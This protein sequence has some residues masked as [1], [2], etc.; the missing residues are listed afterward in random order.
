MRNLITSKKWDFHWPVMEVLIAGKSSIDL[1]HLHVNDFAEATEFIR[2]YGYEP[3]QPDDA[4][5]MQATMIEAIHFIVKFLIP[6]E[7]KTK[8]QIPAEIH[9]CEDV[10]K[11][12][13]FASDRDPQ[14]LSR[15]LWAC[16]I[17]RVMH[18]IAHLEGVLML[19][20]HEIA[21][22]QIYSRFSRHIHHLEDG[23]VLLGEGDNLIELERVEWKKE[24]SRESM[25]LKLLH[26]PA[27]VAETIYDPIGVRVITKKLSDVM[28]VVKFLRQLYM[29]SFPNCNPTRARNT[30]LD[31][32][33]FRDNLDSIDE[34]LAAGELS[35]EDVDEML[36]K[37]TT[38]AYQGRGM[39]GVN[40]H[41][42]N[43]YRAI[44]ITCRQLIR[45]PE[46]QLG[47]VPKMSEAIQ[48]GQLP[49]AVAGV[50][51]ESLRLV[52]N[53]AGQPVKDEAAFF[54]FEVQIMDASSYR[55]TL[56][57]DAAHDR[58]KR[59]QLRSARR[60]VI[61]ELIKSH[62]ERDALKGG[63]RSRKQT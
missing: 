35:Q 59:S 24:K 36:E 29:V 28:I 45:W 22:Q 33:K 38:P 48:N 6:E 54:P 46:P 53:W 20:D 25:L 62:G 14:N 61:G 3:D 13:M 39:L 26:K 31:M 21:F 43:N 4:R 5:Y 42:S 51:R 27:N 10:R 2:C 30:L 50:L 58:Y 15:Q 56:I 8:L 49:D 12:L 34:M 18:T 9:Q 57:G 32:Q 11:L 23:R 47:W 16:A 37:L 40:P 17:L 52:E 55:S 44:Q 63:V 41:S 7:L 1:S 19:A 60:R